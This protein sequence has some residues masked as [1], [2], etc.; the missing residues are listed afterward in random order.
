MKMINSGRRNEKTAMLI[1]VKGLRSASEIR[2]DA[3]QSSLVISLAEEKSI[4]GNPRTFSFR[5][6][7]ARAKAAGR[8]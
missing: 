4:W 1:L 6:G 7:Q 8:G 3:G 2:F 5:I